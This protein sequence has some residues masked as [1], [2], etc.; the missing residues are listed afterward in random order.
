MADTIIIKVRL[1]PGTWDPLLQCLHLDKCLLE[2]HNTKKLW[3]TKNSSVHTII[4]AKLWTKRPQLNCY[5]LVRRGK[6]RVLA[7][8][9][10]HSIT[11]GVGRPPKPP[12]W[13][14]PQTQYLHL[15]S[16]HLKDQLTPPQGASKGT[17]HLFLVL[18]L[19]SQ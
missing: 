1:E 13:P 11:K 4:W 9:P 15:P 16:P 5:F 18:L 6:S 17:C 2:Q 14:D 8:I 7:M 10:A 3:G 12:L 19:Q